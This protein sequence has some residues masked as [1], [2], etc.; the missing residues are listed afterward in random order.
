MKALGDGIMS[1]VGGVVGNVK[2]AMSQIRALLP[3]SDA[4]TGPLSDLTYSGSMLPATFAK[5]IMDNAGVIANTMEQ[6]LPSPIASQA[7]PIPS[8]SIANNS[9]SVSSSPVN[10]TINLNGGGSPDSNFIQ[11][12]EEKGDEVA[13]IV[14]DAIESR[15]RTA[16]VTG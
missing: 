6:V 13:R 14:V 5:G 11:Q 3:G 1:A 9:S 10:V 2:G 12:L 8:N 15:Q 7:L 4:E 16:Y